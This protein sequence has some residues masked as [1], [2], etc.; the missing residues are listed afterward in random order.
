MRVVYGAANRSKRK[1]IRI[2]EGESSA[3]VVQMMGDLIQEVWGSVGRSSILG[4]KDKEHENCE[5]KLKYT[6]QDQS[7]SRRLQGAISFL[8]PDEEY[9]GGFSQMGF[10]VISCV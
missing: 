3:R 9:L 1:V 7:A 2:K 8:I 5:S 6:S 4:E 10:H